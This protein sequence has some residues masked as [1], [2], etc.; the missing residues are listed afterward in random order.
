MTSHL[1]SR[2]RASAVVVAAVLGALIAPSAFAGPTAQ[3]TPLPGPQKKIVEVLD[4]IAGKDRQAG[5]TPAEAVEAPTGSLAPADAASAGVDVT[6]CAGDRVISAMSGE[7][8]T[9]KV[10]IVGHPA[11]FEIGNV[12]TT[13]WKSPPS[14]S[15]VWQLYFRGFYWMGQLAPQMAD[16]GDTA[17]LDALVRTAVTFNRVNPDPGTSA[18]GWD[19]GT[20]LRRQQNLNCLYRITGGDPRLVPVIEAFA[21][22][23]LDMSRYY[24]LPTHLPHNHGLMA[25]LALIDSADLLDRPAW[26]TAAVDR[27]VRDSAGVWTPSGFT[28]EQSAAYGQIN[29]RLW[30]DVARLLEGYA[31]YG[32]AVRSIDAGC[33]KARGALSHLSS[34]LGDITPYGDATPGAFTAAAQA[35][36][37]VRDDTAGIITGRWSWSNAATSHYVLRYGGPRRMHGHQ[38]RQSLVWTTRGVP[39]LVD[40]GDFSYDPGPYTSFA[41]N[42]I[43]HNV[44]IVHKSTFSLAAGVGVVGRTSSG[45]IHAVSLRDAQYGRTHHR[46]WRMDNGRGAVSVTDS[47]AAASVTTMH[48]AAPWTLAS[49]SSDGR[50]VVLTH[51][52]GRRLT[53][54]GTHAITVYR[55]LTRPVLGW[56]F[57]QRGYREHAT[58]LLMQTPAGTSSMT[59]TVS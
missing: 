57:P 5:L 54:K 42:P 50:T 11:T 39:V 16:S 28:I 56:V 14:S 15:A 46:I 55:G 2:R 1:G 27:L 33:A 52:S 19:E 47:V 12:P 20:N 34:P 9:R 10:T 8:A 51:P 23:N 35:S 40:P 32:A 58:Q 3:P 25:N 21:K 48:L 26:R 49:R 43:G 6:G 36:G 4:D 31:V 38:D 22:A 53:A 45:S 41:R 44:Q 59:L 29:E 24:G 17:G 18:Y 37:G 30:T 13:W 7:G